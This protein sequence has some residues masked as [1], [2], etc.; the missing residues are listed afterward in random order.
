M[1]KTEIISPNALKVVV[2]DKSKAD[3]LR[4]IAPQ[5]DALISQHGKIRDPVVVD[6][7]RRQCRHGKRNRRRIRPRMSVSRSL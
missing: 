5:I 7:P 2:P 1:I 3:D 6:T 4:Q